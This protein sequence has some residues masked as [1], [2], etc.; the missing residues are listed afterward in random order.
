MAP[1]LP[2]KNL[3]DSCININMIAPTNIND[4]KSLLLWI[5]DNKYNDIDWDAVFR[6][7]IDYSMDFY[8]S[9]YKNINWPRF[10]RVMP[11]AFLIRFKIFIVDWTTQIVFSKEVI[12]FELFVEVSHKLDWAVISSNPPYWLNEMHMIQFKDKFDWDKLIET[13]KLAQQQNISFKWLQQRLGY[14][15]YLKGDFYKS[16]HHYQQALT[17]DK[18]DELSHLYLY[19]SNVA[20]GHLMQARYHAAL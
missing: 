8:A 11:V 9:F 3:H 16:K 5:R 14:A 2:I 6:M 20:T 12:P 7:D 10:H 18:H 13:G 15:W 1:K 4:E 19:L 17:F